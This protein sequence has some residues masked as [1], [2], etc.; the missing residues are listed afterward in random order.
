[1]ATLYFDGRSV[2]MGCP[3]GKKAVCSVSVDLSEYDG[4]FI[5]YYFR[6]S[7]KVGYVTSPLRGVWVDISKEVEFEVDD[8]SGLTPII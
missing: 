6:L 8:S 5:N 2:D 3:S 4:M 7:D 1:S